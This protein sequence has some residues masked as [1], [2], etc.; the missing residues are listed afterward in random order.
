MPIRLKY[1]VH[2]CLQPS[3]PKGAEMSIRTTFIAIISL[4]VFIAGAMTFFAYSSEINASRARLVGASKVIET[5]SGPIEYAEAGEGPVVL[6]VHGAGGGF[7]QGLDI[8]K[9]LV[10]QGFKVIAMS[11]FGYL[12]TP[13]AADGSAASQAKAHASL[14]DALQIK[15]AATFGVSAGGPSALQFAIDYPERCT[16]L[17]LMVPLAYK[18]QDVPASVPT[19]SPFT[20]KILMTIV[21]S[22]FAF[23]L[24]TKLAPSLVTKTVLG[25][26]P[27]I[28]ANASEEEKNRIRSFMKSILPISSRVR[29]IVNDSK[30]SASLK[31]FEFEKVKAPTL[32]LSVRDDLYGTF[33]SSEYT[34]K[35]IPGA[36]FIGYETGG[37]MLIGHDDQA[38]TEITTFLKANSRA[39]NIPSQIFGELDK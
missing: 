12:R 15:Q 38:N 6:V 20:E 28:A 5:A 32:I 8:A 23:W 35:Q 37:H 29:G 9:P 7:D 14:L 16:A 39:N 31:R 34:A 3:K 24:G 17:V 19:L 1:I 2:H 21:G 13:P 4:A 33:A 18:P 36:K 26:P 30:I 22:D 11:R 10:S 27:E 25:T